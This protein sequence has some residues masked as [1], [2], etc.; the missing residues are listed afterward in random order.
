MRESTSLNNVFTVLNLV[1][2]GVV[3]VAGSMKGTY[4]QKRIYRVLRNLE[5]IYLSDRSVLF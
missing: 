2:I 1:T 4:K 3:I 5:Q